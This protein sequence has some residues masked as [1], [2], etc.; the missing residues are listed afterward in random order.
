MFQVYFSSNLAWN[1]R[2]P[3]PL[4]GMNPCGRNEMTIMKKKLIAD[5]EEKKKIGTLSTK[6]DAN[7]KLIKLKH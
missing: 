4:I 1:V 7:E 3:P 5:E 6:Y 2:P